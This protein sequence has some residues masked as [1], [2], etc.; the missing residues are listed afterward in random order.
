[1]WHPSEV[2][3]FTSLSLQLWLLSA[4]RDEVKSKPHGKRDCHKT[5]NQDDLAAGDKQPATNRPAPR[6][7]ILK[8]IQPSTHSCA[9]LVYSVDHLAI[10]FAPAAMASPRPGSSSIDRATE[11]S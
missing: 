10:M 7:L 3:R 9:R 6:K 11:P 1:M 8:H 4:A 5:G 2:S